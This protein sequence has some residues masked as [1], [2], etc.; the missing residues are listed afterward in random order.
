MLFTEGDVISRRKFKRGRFSDLLHHDIV[1]VRQALGRIRRDRARNKQHQSPILAPR[2]LKLLLQSAQPPVQLFHLFFQ[3]G[4]G[5]RPLLPDL[6]LNL[7]G[8]P[9]TLL[10]Y[11]FHFLQKGPTLVVPMQ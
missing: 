1:E 11:P 8:K 6:Y 5:V 4:G 3:S 7:R 2:L 9:V 10:P